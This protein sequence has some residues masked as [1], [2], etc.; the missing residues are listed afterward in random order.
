MGSTRT[1]DIETIGTDVFNTSRFSTGAIGHTLTL[2]ADVFQ[3]QV[4]V[5]DPVSTADLF[6]PS[7]KRTVG[8]AFVQDKIGIDIMA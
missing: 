5:T 1:F 3:D 7:G 4:E 8:G 6:T 2:G